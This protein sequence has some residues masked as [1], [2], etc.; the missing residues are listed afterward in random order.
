MLVS[1]NSANRLEIDVI[2]KKIITTRIILTGEMKFADSKLVLKWFCVQ[3]LPEI[4]Y[5]AP[6]YSLFKYFFVSHSFVRRQSEMGAQLYK[7][8]IDFC[9]VNGYWRKVWNLSN[10]AEGKTTLSLR[11]EIKFFLTARSIILYSFTF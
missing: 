6:K 11:V 8:L 1:W 9:I 10:A 2:I 4:F 3:A 5:Y 7:V